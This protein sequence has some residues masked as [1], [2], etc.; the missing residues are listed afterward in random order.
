M[1]TVL[2][3]CVHNAGRSQMAAAFFNALADPTR[4]R[5][6]SAGTQPGARVH[7]E[8][9]AV[10]AEAGIDLSGTLPRLLTDELARN[11]GWLITLGCGDACPVVPGLK[12]DDWPLDDP[13]GQPMPRV[14]EIRDDIRARVVALLKRQDWLLAPSR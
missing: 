14:R 1:E 2:F 11:A 10:M 9:Q 7:P 12:R 5:A 13:K 3:A 6:L 4:A 8:V